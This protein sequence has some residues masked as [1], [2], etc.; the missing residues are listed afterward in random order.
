LKQLEVKNAT[1]KQ[2]DDTTSAGKVDYERRKQIEKEAR[3]VRS[4]IEKEETLIQNLEQKIADID[5]ILTNPG[6]HNQKVSSGELY[7]EYEELKVR[8]E[9]AMHTWEGLHAELDEVQNQ[10]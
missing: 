1:S 5:A 8:L 3:K 2:S 7:T 6:S 4:L 9:K 10:I